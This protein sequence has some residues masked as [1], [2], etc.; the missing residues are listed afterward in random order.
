MN[1]QERMLERQ[2]NVAITMLKDAATLKRNEESMRDDSYN[3]SLQTK[4]DIV[5]TKIDE[6]DMMIT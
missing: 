4:I 3:I 2:K 5:S 6:T 1:M